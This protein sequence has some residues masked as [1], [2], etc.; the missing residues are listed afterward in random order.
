[1][2]QPLFNELHQLSTRLFV[3]IS[4]LWNESLTSK[5]KKRSAYSN[6]DRRRKPIT[7]TDILDILYRSNDFIYVLY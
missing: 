6:P 7:V 3:A 4:D 5:K 2:H 1:M